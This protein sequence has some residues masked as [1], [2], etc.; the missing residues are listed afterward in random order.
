MTNSVTNLHLINSKCELVYALLYDSQSN[1][2]MV[3]AHSN[4]IS[5]LDYLIFA[6][7]RKIVCKL[8]PNSIMKETNEKKKILKF[9]F[10]RFNFLIDRKKIIC[11][12]F[13][14]TE[15]IF[16]TKSK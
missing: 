1:L 11:D 12:L 5:R 2:Y 8:I 16:K 14:R 4:G 9:H 7:F 3:P 10:F 6:S 15:N 13:M